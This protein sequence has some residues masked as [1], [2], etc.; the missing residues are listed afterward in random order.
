MPKIKPKIIK[1]Y[2]L[3]PILEELEKERPGNYR[4]LEI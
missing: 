3:F 2:D 1:C 4:K